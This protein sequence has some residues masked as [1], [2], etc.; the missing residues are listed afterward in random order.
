MVR[1]LRL[2]DDGM[3]DFC[4]GCWCLQQYDYSESCWCI[5]GTG[6]APSATYGNCKPRIIRIFN[7]LLPH[8]YSL[9]TITLRLVQADGASPVP[10]IHHG[11]SAN[12]KSRTVQNALFTEFR[13]RAERGV[14]SVNGRSSDTV[15]TEPDANVPFE[16]GVAELKRSDIG[17]DESAP[18]RSVACVYG[19]RTWHNLQITS[20]PF[21]FK[22]IALKSIKFFCFFSFKKRRRRRPLVTT[23][24][25]TPSLFV[26]HNEVDV[27]GVVAG[28]I[29]DVLYVGDAELFELRTK[30]RVAP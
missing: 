14:K 21:H 13:C 2:C 23:V 26:T 27:S 19:D 18:S 16:R 29:E 11:E 6:L 20:K 10:T 15:P 30:P 1:S 28:E 22:A 17:L 25:L 5:V 8:F 7:N 12:P 4:R 24:P 3:S 9:K